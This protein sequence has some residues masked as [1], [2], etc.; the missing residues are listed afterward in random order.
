MDT[1]HEKHDM[2]LAAT[3]CRAVEAASCAGGAV[4]VKQVGVFAVITQK[5]SLH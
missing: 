2:S 5:I 1:T 4:R 3:Q